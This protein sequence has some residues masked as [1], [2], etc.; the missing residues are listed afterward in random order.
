MFIKPISIIGNL[1]NQLTDNRSST[2]CQE[3]CQW[4]T[5]VKQRVLQLFLIKCDVVLPM[6]TAPLLANTV[7]NQPAK[8]D[9]QTVQLLGLI[10]EL[11][12]FC[13]EHHTYNIKNC[14]L[15][16]DL[17]RRILVLM[18]SNHTFLV[19]CEYRKLYPSTILGKIMSCYENV[20]IH[21]FYRECFRTGNVLINL[22]KFDL[23]LNF[24]LGQRVFLN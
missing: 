16:K 13:V 20:T 11:L 23:T 2:V 21:W 1:D 5:I 19:L 9:Y 8:D 14:I 3:K 6:I 15:S 10:L 17:L 4:S 22:L 24:L 12:S 7:D 18:K